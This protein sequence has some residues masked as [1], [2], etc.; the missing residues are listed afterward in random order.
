MRLILWIILKCSPFYKKALA[1]P[2]YRYIS[3]SKL[4]S[5]F[6][7]GNTRPCKSS[8][9]PTI[10]NS[11]MWIKEVSLLQQ[12]DAV[13]D[14]S[15]IIF[16]LYAK[17]Q[18]GISIEL[19]TWASK[20]TNLDCIPPAVDLVRSLMGNKLALLT[21]QRNVFAKCQ[22]NVKKPRLLK[23]L[24]NYFIK[25]HNDSGRFIQNENVS[26]IYWR[27]VSNLNYS[28]RLSLHQEESL[29]Q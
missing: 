4:I 16:A 13:L 19:F 29:E 6:F 15:L 17:K 9:S 26:D 22:I 1:T 23:S 3:M 25:V 2:K 24:W 27:F 28:P 14:S 18:I 8:P 12:C 20:T 7:Y 5:L 10:L 11:A 21:T